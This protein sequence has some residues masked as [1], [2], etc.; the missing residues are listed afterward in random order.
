MGMTVIVRSQFC[1][2][3]T[4]RAIS[5]TSPSAPNCGIS[6]Q[7][8][9]RMRSLLVSWTLAT[10]DSSVSRKMSSTI[11]IIA[12]NPLTKNHGDWP[13]SRATMKTPA[14]TYTNTLASC[15]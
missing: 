9:T 5:T 12:P 7:S 2:F 3:T 15:T 14:T 4:C 13:A 6:I 10:S 1:T 11:A 8:P